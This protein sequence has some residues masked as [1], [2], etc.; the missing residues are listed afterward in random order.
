MSDT[1]K[2]VASESAGDGES[3]LHS[4][5][6]EPAGHAEADSNRDGTAKAS[7]A[8][9]EAAAPASNQ[10]ADNAAQQ[11]KQTGG[12]RNSIDQGGSQSKSGRGGGKKGKG[13]RTRAKIVDI[14]QPP[15]FPGGTN[16]SAT[17]TAAA[18]GS[19]R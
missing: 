7:S 16:G 6:T 12:R 2:P 14:S 1:H 13:G 18:P 8:K 9:P 3:G 10:V 4:R 5:Q 15:Q 17:S 11:Q 19:T